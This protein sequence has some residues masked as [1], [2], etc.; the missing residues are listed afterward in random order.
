MPSLGDDEPD[1]GVRQE[2]VDEGED[3]NPAV[4]QP[5]HRL[6]V[7]QAPAVRASTAPPQVPSG[8]RLA[9]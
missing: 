4:H 1:D 8:A 9:Q 5:S 7:F 2:E 3:Q 6:L